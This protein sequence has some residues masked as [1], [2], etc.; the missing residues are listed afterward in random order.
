MSGSISSGAS[1]GIEGVVDFGVL[2]ELAVRA[3]DAEHVD[4]TLTSMESLVA[5]V[6][7][8]VCEPV[9]RSGAA[10]RGRA[11]EDEATDGAVARVGETDS[12]SELVE[13]WRSQVGWSAVGFRGVYGGMQRL[14][15]WSRRQYRRSK[16]QGFC[17]WSF[18]GTQ[19]SQERCP[20]R[21]VDFKW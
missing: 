6:D 17:A 1:S 16:R 13:R 20:C 15:R 10:R 5:A 11:G 14:A 19:M 9:R 7:S 12:S 2:V 21:H 3:G 4:G 8:D 18:F